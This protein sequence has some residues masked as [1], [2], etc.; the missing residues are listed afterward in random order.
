[1]LKTPLVQAIRTT[2]LRERRLKELGIETVEDLLMFF[3]WR[4]T[5]QREVARTID[6]KLN[7]VNVIRGRLLTIKNNSPWRRKMEITTALIGDESGAVEAVWFNQPYLAKILAKGREVIV[8]G[9][10]K[11]NKK[12][13]RM[14][15]QN[16][17]VEFIKD[18]QIHT[19][20]IVPVYHETEIGVPQRRNFAKRSYASRQI[21]GK[22]SSKWIREKL[23]PLMDFADEFE[24][25]M[26]MEVLARYKLMPLNKA[27]R[28]VHFPETEKNLDDAKRRLGFDELFLIQLA[29]LHRRYLWR[30]ISKKEKKQMPSDW[31]LM[32]S[33]TRSLPWPL[34]NAQKKA[35][36]EII[37][38]LEKP[39]PMSRLLAGDTGSG[40]TVVAAAAALH[41]IK[42]GWQVCLLAPT[43]ILACQHLKTIG[44][45]LAEFKIK[46]V[47]LTGSTPTKDKKSVT[48]SL[49]NGSCSLVIGTHALLQEG[50]SFKRLGLAIIDEQHRFGVRQR[51]LLKTHESPHILNLTATPIP[52]T[53]ALVLYGDHDLSILDEMP[54]GR[55]KIITR[56]VPE[57]KRLKA[58]NWIKNEIEKG[59]QAFIIFPLIEGKDALEER[60]NG[61]ASPRLGLSE[62]LQI[63][64]AVSEFERLKNEIFP[65]LSIGLLHGRMKSEEKGAAMQAFNK[66]KIQILVSTAVV[67][68]GVDV[69]NA[70]IM[71]IEGAERFGLAQLHQFRGRVGRG[72][73]QSYCFLFPT[74]QIPQILQRL[75][76]LVKYNSGFKLAEVDL[77]LRGPGEVYGTAQSGIPDLKMASLG[78]S[79]LIKETRAAATY[80][81]ECD[82]ELEKHPK[83][84]EKIYEQQNVAIDY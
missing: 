56:V 5:D 30:K 78:N 20:R 63:K 19:A 38:D 13:E 60:N 16:P 53:L 49:A 12:R 75:N 51:E 14:F 11:Y 6:I 27:I 34:T 36:Y 74:L 39:F 83:L 33:F 65:T 77:Q 41:A 64:A 42:A 40:K 43:E 18:Q 70:T 8:S 21:H 17:T 46:P 45:V 57:N 25:F 37:K 55:Q 58:Y 1:M 54:P 47:L 32:K 68:V 9:K 31:E 80:I 76:A 52:R 7:E 79:E 82:P 67:E 15:L 28:N 3:P 24:D 62:E 71:M 4:Y 50:I 59:S 29:A 23:F 48:F 44:K 22:I 73:K 26:P 66:G 69:P 84:K 35:V 2:A 61:L 72:I 10:A 81:I